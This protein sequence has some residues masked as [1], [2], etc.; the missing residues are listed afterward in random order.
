MNEMIVGEITS[1]ATQVF[2]TM[3][4][5]EISA[6]RTTEGVAPA[7]PNGV[8]GLVGLTGALTGSGG[9]GCGPGLACRIAAAMCP[10]D[11]PTVDEI[12]LDAMGEMANLV[13]GSLKTQLENHVGPMSIS[14]PT[15][16]FGQHLYVHRA[17]K[18]ESKTVYF[19]CEGDPFWVQLTLDSTGSLPA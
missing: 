18:R 1:A 9:I 5:M 17:A 16:V 3:L 10:G 14:V 6:E 19:T 12:V 4:G 8:A 7:D 11:Y 15:V 13:I 2:S